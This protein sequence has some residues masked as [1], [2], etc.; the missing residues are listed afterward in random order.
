VSH[1]LGLGVAIEVA[2]EASPIFGGPLTE[3]VDEGLYKI[4]AGSPQGLGTAEVSRITFDQSRVK[5][6][7]AD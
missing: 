7:L 3:V 1:L 2:D 6:M 5:L 4:P